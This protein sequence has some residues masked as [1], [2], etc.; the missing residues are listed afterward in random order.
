MRSKVV[1]LIPFLCFPVVDRTFDTVIGRVS[2][3]FLIRVV[4]DTMLEDV[5]EIGIRKVCVVI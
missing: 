3:V 4:L 2:D 5:E 1:V